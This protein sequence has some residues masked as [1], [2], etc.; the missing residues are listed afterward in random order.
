MSRFLAAALATASFLC[1]GQKPADAPV[2]PSDPG[3]EVVVQ[4][5]FDAMAARDAIAA[6]ALFVLDAGLFSL[7]ANGKANRMPLDDFLNVLGSGKVEWK[8]RIWNAT[9]LVHGPIAVVWAP[10]DFHLSGSFTHCGYDSI[11]LLKTLAGWKITYISDTRETEGCVNP[12]G[13]PGRS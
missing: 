3:P 8:E 4:Q 9:V 6:K 12:V 13:P 1:A 5:L 11:S 2:P 10:Y 7:G